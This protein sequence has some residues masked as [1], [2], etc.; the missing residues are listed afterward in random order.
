MLHK[1]ILITAFLIFA[2]VVSYA[3]SCALR[4]AINEAYDGSDIVMIVKIADI[5]KQA[6]ERDRTGAYATVEKIYKGAVKPGERILIEGGFTSCD[7]PIGE[8]RIGKDLLLFSGMP[9]EGIKGSFSFTRCGHD[10]WVE[11]AGADLLYLDNLQKV[12]GKSR[13]S[14]TLTYQE[15]SPVKGRS[16]RYYPLEGRRVTIRGNEKT[17][18]AVTDKNG[19][20]EIYDLPQGSYTIS[21]PENSEWKVEGRLAS[22]DYK[23]GKD[24]DAKFESPEFKAVEVKYEMYEDNRPVISLYLLANRHVETN[25]EYGPRNELRGIVTGP[26]G[27]P[28]NDVHLDLVTAEGNHQYYLGCFD[29]TNEAGKFLFDDVPP[30]KYYLVANYI[31][32]EA[33]TDKISAEQPFEGIIYPGVKER[34][35]A[36]VIEIKNGD[37]RRGFDF[38]IPKVYET[39]NVSGKFIFADGKP[40][41]HGFISFKAENSETGVDRNAFGRLDDKTGEFDFKVLKGSKG[42]LIPEVFIDDKIYAACTGIKDFKPK[43]EN[44]GISHFKADTIPII[45]DKDINGLEIKLPFKSC[46]QPK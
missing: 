13:L 6:S 2:N 10:E 1:F 15:D 7:R 18:E 45:A 34:S 37:N 12:R 17:Y 31:P 32:W 41:T 9:K 3:C 20:W 29:N 36:T 39:V 30:G 22:W 27:K 16:G 8:N 5:K 4:G 40:V 43:V 46:Q 11:F 21:V 42:N 25:H 38:K 14:G 35:Q 26:D 24:L 44:G 23:F 19:V 28:L 33:R